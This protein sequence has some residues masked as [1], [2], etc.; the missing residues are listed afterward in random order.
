MN[1]SLT[2]DEASLVRYAC[3]ELANRRSEQAIDARVNQNLGWKATNEIADANEKEA[4]AYRKIADR[5]SD[6]TRKDL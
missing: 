6:L 3:N 2:N 4:R 5:I 1:L